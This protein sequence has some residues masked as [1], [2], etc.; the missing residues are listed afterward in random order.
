MSQAWVKAQRAAQFKI[1]VMDG[2]CHFDKSKR[3]GPEAC[4]PSLGFV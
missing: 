2:V 4:L 1:A 3:Q